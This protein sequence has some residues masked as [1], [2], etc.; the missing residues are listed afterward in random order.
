[1]AD[2]TTTRAAATAALAT[3]EQQPGFQNYGADREEAILDLIADLAHLADGLGLSGRRVLDSA[4]DHYEAE[5]GEFDDTE[6]VP[7][8]KP[9]AASVLHLRA[10]H[11]TSGNPRRCFA[12]F[13]AGGAFLAAI[14]EGYEGEQALYAQFPEARNIW[15]V[16]VD[17]PVSEYKR[18]LRR[19]PTGDVAAIEQA[20]QVRS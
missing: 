5:Q 10:N 12:V 15:P 3:Y 1:M 4:S 18:F 6:P 20:L 14:D 7:E 9:R 13:A 2:T 17:V 8:Q 16:Q 19:I 11:T